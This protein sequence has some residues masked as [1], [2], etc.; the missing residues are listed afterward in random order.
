MYIHHFIW[1]AN[2]Q[3]K[4]IWVLRSFHKSENFNFV[5]GYFKVYSPLRFKIILILFIKQMLLLL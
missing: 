3:N 1:E 5:K 2:N 4:M